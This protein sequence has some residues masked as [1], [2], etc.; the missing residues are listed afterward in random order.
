MKIIFIAW[1]AIEV[2]F[3][4][5]IIFGWASLVYVYKSEGFFNYKCPDS[6]R[7]EPEGHAV[8]HT[9]DQNTSDSCPFCTTESNYETIFTDNIVQLAWLQL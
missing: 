3:F 6:D 8:V 4:G 1:G 7:F 5:G 9:S 2:L